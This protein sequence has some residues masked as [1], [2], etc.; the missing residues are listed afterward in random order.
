MDGRTRNTNTKRA[1]KGARIIYSSKIQEIM[2]VHDPGT[3]QETDCVYLI[4]AEANDAIFNISQ[5]H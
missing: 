1:C 5:T 2:E 3:Q 4:L